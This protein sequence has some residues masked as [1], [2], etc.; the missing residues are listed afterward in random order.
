MTQNHVSIFDAHR[1]DHNPF[2]IAHTIYSQFPSRESRQ[3]SAPDESTEQLAIKRLYHCYAHLSQN[4]PMTPKQFINRLNQDLAHYQVLLHTL[5]CQTPP[6]KL[7]QLFRINDADGHLDATQQSVTHR[8]NY[9][10]PP[11]TPPTPQQIKQDNAGLTTNQ[12]NSRRNRNTT[13]LM[14]GII[15]FSE[16]FGT[17][18]LTEL[19]IAAHRWPDGKPVCPHCGDTNGVVFQLNPPDTQPPPHFLPWAR[20]GPIIGWDC[21]SCQQQFTA[22]TGTLFTNPAFPPATWLHFAY[23]MIIERGGA[24]EPYLTTAAGA[25]HAIVVTQHEAEQMR[26]LIRSAIPFAKPYTRQTVSARDAL[27]MLI[28]HFSNNC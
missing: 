15:E 7:E 13:K 23:E 25:Y 27:K 3:Y 22:T 5:D 8:L 21:K 17:P 16:V 24:Y 20:S 1:H 10:D 12:R 2:A 6:S 19:F 28:K 4:S 26:D 14:M 11:K 9:F 18:L